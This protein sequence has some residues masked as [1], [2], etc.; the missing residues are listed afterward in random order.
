MYS[1]IVKWVCLA[2]LVLAAAVV[3]HGVPQILLQ[4]VICG[5]ATFVMIEAFRSQE[6]HMG[7]RFC[8]DCS[9]FQ[10]HRTF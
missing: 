5:G 2:A 10:S 8:A 1:I 6:I 3:L 4:F 9:V 7:G